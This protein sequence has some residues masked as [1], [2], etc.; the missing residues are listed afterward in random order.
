MPWYPRHFFDPDFD[1]TALKPRPLARGRCD[2]RNL[3]YARNVLPGQV[4]AELTPLASA[5]GESGAGDRSPFHSGRPCSARR[6]AYRP[7][8]SSSP[9]PAGHGGGLRIP[10]GGAH[11]G[12]DPA[13]RARRRGFPYRQHRLCRR[14]SFT[15][16]ATWAAA[17]LFRG[18]EVLVDGGVFGGRVRARGDL[19]VQG[20][21]RG[22]NANCLLSAGRNLRIGFADKAELR[23]GNDLDIDQ[24]LRSAL[25]AGGAPCRAPQPERRRM[26][27]ARARARRGRRSG[28]R[29]ARPHPGDPGRRPRVVPPPAPLFRTPATGA[30]GETRGARAPPWPGTCPPRCQRL[31]PSPGPRPPRGPYSGKTAGF[32]SGR[33]GTRA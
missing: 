10:R 12:Q 29:L 16:T 7:R 28:A 6:S 18:T 30:P 4:L 17:L 11:R 2:M 21:A 32:S 24:A 22:D 31:R 13:Q 15:S 33:A 25:L 8:S 23:A 27:G 1:H 26:P 19:A 14:S 20:G 9:A 5:G 3:G